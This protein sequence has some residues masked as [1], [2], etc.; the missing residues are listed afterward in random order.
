[1]TGAVEWR[2]RVGDSWAD[3]WRR[4]DRSFVGLDPHLVA[5]ILAAAPERGRALDI[6]CGAGATALAVA[7][8]RP[9]LEIVGVDLSTALISVARERAADL[10][11]IDL[12]VGDALDAADS[13]EPFDLM[14]SRHGVMFFDDPGVAFARLHDA[15]A[16]RA[17]LVFSCFRARSDNGWASEIAAALGQ[18]SPRDTG[19]RGGPG[20]FAFADRHEV[21]AMLAGAGWTEITATPV[22][23]AYRAGAGGDPVADAVS[24]FGRIG[25]AAA[26]LA[27]AAEDDRAAMRVRLAEMCQ[28]RLGDGVVD[29]PAA[30]WLWSA[31]A[32][33]RRSDRA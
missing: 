1:L 30:A 5:A 6:G 18:P 21:E 29:F 7:A 3:E 25:P 31:R 14:F 11:A 24:F 26:T 20:P 12:V 22:D 4:T 23:Y 16:P 15:C 27:A 8:G 13:G 9:E 10:P 2:A 19:M 17:A 28:A 33:R 32:S